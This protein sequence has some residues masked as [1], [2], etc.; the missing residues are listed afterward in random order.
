MISC[1]YSSADLQLVVGV[2]RR[3]ARRAVEAALGLI[4]VGVGDRRAHVVEREPV[5]GERLR[6]HLD[7]HGGPLAAA[8]ADEAHAGELRDLLRDPRVGEILELRQRQRLRRERQREDRRVGRIDLVV[9]RRI[10]QVGRQEIARRVDR[11]LHFLL[12]DVERQ[13]EAE[14]QRDHRCAAGA[15]RRHLVQSRHLPELALERRGDRRRHH[16]GAR[17]RIE[18][19][20]LDRR[21]VDFGQ[22][23]QRQHAIRDDAREQDR[24]H[25]QRRRDRAQDEQA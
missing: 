18:R 7:A 5:R 20:H 25:Q 8:D 12:G 15:R 22:R 17:A 4:G 2:D 9:D 6:I 11:R 24:D 14:L 10:R 23:G 21:I 3:R 16:V 13:L 19:H 1:R